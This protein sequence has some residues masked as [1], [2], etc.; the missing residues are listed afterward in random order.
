MHSVKLAGRAA[1]VLAFAAATVT[2]VAV[3][4]SAQTVDKATF[5]FSGDSGD[6]ISG[7]QSYAYDTAAN[8]R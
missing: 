2:A 4:A 7:G 8:D 1:A 5:A 6:W 3:P